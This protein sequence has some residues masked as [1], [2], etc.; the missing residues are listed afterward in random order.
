MSK[1]VRFLEMLGSNPALARD[2]L[3][4]REER[5]A[6]LDVD[7]VRRRALLARDAGRLGTLLGGRLRMAMNVIA[8]DD[9]D[10]QEDLPQ[11]DGDE[12]QVETEQPE[13]A[14]PD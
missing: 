10:T 8:P 1:E 9:G 11:R 6:T 2:A 14:E 3:L 12:Q 13:R 5:M 4:A 7:P